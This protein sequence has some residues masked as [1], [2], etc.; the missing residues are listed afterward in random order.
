[1]L[2]LCL[3]V[4]AKKEKSTLLTGGIEYTVETA[5]QEA[6]DGIE[7]TIPLSMLKPYLKDSNYGENKKAMRNGQEDLSDRWIGYFS[8]GRYNVVYKNDRYKEYSYSS[9]GRLRGI[10]IRTSLDFPVKGYT[11]N[12]FGKLED[13]TFYVKV[14]NDSHIYVYTPEGVLTSHWINNKCYDKD[15]KVV[16]ESY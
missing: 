8:N 13:V 16:L 4:E 11:Y 9:N 5:R 1:M 14:N 7:Y 3:P 10:T 12:I 15:G 2:V 6:F